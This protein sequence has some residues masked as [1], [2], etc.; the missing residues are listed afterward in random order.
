MPQQN[1]SAFTPLN[2]QRRAIPAWLLSAVVHGVILIVAVLAFRG[3]THG[4]PDEAPRNIGIALAE[5]SEAGEMQYFSEEKAAPL[6]GGES[7]EPAESETGDNTGL[8]AALP[9][10][11]AENSLV[12]PDLDLPGQP[13]AGIGAASKLLVAASANGGG[14][15]LVLPGSD[16]SA[17]IASEMADR[18]ARR[19]SGPVA[20]V[21]LFGGKAASGRTFL[22]VID[23]S[24]SMGEDGYGGLHA[25]QKEL[26]KQLKSL[27]PEHKFQIIAYH[28]KPVYLLGKRDLLP[29][30]TENVD[31]IPAYF[32]GLAAFG[33]TEHEM[34]L[35]AALRLK[36]DAIFFLTDGGDPYLT[37]G[38]IERIATRAG[39]STTIHC[40][41]FGFDAAPKA[42]NFMQ[43]LA[44][45]CGGGYGYMN[46]RNRK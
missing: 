2:P 8:T 40:I 9:S 12:S 21:S 46:M 31:S 6:S 11:A 15:R 44:S 33:A 30:T 3:V 26:H 45:R 10:A 13:E 14:R 37:D 17:F 34:A 1:M 5:I 32:D 35:L 25:A 16:D 19:P 24:K 41:E 22:F 29:A 4:L 27:T 36:P 42:D 18:I 43:R 7:R 20:K 28:H 23:R 39:Q 38:Q